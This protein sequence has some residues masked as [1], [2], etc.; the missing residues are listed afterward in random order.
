[1]ARDT[2][3]RFNASLH[4]QHLSDSICCIFTPP[5]VCIEIARYIYHNV[6]KS[7]LKE[8]FVSLF[9]DYLPPSSCKR[10]LWV[11]DPWDQ[12]WRIIFNFMQLNSYDIFVNFYKVE[13]FNGG[14][15]GF[16]H[17]FWTTGLTL[18]KIVTFFS[19]FEASSQY[20]NFIQ[21][22]ESTS[23][24]HNVSKCLF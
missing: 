21:D 2:P 13:N 7:I 10:S 14:G 5:C 17:R 20:K 23:V 24:G 16:Q 12:I 15:C 9:L 4:I 11:N 19:S 8:H 18:N 6:W 22:Q 3:K 1:M